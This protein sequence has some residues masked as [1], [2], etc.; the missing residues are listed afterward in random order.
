MTKTRK[1][2]IDDQKEKICFSCGNKVS[3]YFWK[4]H[5]C[6]CA[7]CYEEIENKISKDMK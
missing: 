6:L 3:K 5:N 1:Q 2:I 4:T 7:P